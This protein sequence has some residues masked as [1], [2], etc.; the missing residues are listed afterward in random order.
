MHSCQHHFTLPAIQRSVALE[1]YLEEVKSDLAD[2]KLPKPRNNLLPAER[3]F[4]NA[5]KHNNEINIKKA[6]KGTTT[7]V[8]NAQDKRQEGQIQLDNMNDY[9]PL[10]TLW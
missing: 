8:I 5:L 7:V 1:S 10:E 9:S 4:L 2:L 3:E 6:D